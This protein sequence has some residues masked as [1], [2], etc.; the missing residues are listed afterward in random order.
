MGCLSKKKKKRLY[1]L[2]P[3]I[4]FITMY[5][6]K[7]KKCVY[8]NLIFLLIYM[9]VCI[10]IYINN[11]NLETVHRYQPIPKYFVILD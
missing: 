2:L 6:K 10:Y 5:V 8:K 7:K 1:G 11:N 4:K 9:C 3:K